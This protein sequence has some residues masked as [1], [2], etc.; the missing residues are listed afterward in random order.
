MNP[1]PTSHLATRPADI[2]HFHM[3]VFRE[4]GRHDSGTGNGSVRRSHGRPHAQIRV[5]VADDHPITLMGLQTLLAAARDV[6]VVARCADGHDAIRAVGL[7]EADILVSDQDLPGLD[8]VAVLKQLRSG[9]DRTRLVLLATTNNQQL[10]DALSLGVHGVVFKQSDPTHLV[11]CLREVHAGRRWL[12][13]SVSGDRIVAPEARIPRTLT[14]RQIEVARAA[15]SGLSNKELAQRLGVSE[16]TV[17]NHLH[18]IYERLKVDGRLAL[19]LYLQQ[20]AAA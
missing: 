15:V 13:A 17:K 11:R 8:G 6:T 14:A 12:D 1:N 7:Y 3:T 10:A 16:G 5:V 18:A 20:N 2:R 19:L 9:G 4:D